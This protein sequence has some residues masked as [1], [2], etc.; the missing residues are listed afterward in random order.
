MWDMDNDKSKQSQTP[1]SKASKENILSIF[2]QLQTKL[3]DQVEWRTTGAVV[4]VKGPQH[5][6]IN[7]IPA[8]TVDRPNPTTED[9]PEDHVQDRETTKEAT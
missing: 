5:C 2:K 8:F 9:H 1:V 4:F 7:Q 3:Y 6:K